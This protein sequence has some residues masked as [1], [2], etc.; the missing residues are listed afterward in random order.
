M[1]GIEVAGLVLGAIPLVITAFG[2]YNSTFSKVKE[3]RCYSREAQRIVRCLRLEDA[4][5]QSV[6][7]KLLGGLVPVTD[8]E[9]MIE[10]PGC[11]LRAEGLDDKMRLRLWKLGD[12]FLGT[13]EDIKSAIDAIK[14]KLELVDGK[15]SP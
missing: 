6:C 11:Q 7:E 15:V 1:S 10:H 4:R 14:D 12:D 9:S 2:T 5:L 3:W 13:I 8:I